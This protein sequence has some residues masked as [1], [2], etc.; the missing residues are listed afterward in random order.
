MLYSRFAAYAEVTFER[1]HINPKSCI[2]R[3]NLENPLNLA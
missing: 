2:V 1:E 3:I